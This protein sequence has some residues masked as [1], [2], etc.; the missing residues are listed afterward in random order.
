MEDC[1]SDIHLWRRIA[2]LFG[3]QSLHTT[4]IRIRLCCHHL[5]RQRADRR[6]PL[7]IV[8]TGCKGQS[9]L[10]YGL[11]LTCPD[12]PN[13]LHQLARWLCNRYREGATRRMQIPITIVSHPLTGPCSGVQTRITRFDGAVGWVEY[14]ETH[15]KDRRR[16]VSLTF[17]PSYKTLLII[18]RRSRGEG[19][20]RLARSGQRRQLNVREI[21]LARVRLAPGRRSGA[22]PLRV[23]PRPRLSRPPYQRREAGS[24]NRNSVHG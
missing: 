17:S 13:W 16:W 6:I 7:A 21:L 3:E 22:S 23:I 10:G 4:E 11:Q 12:Q 8:A 20:R 2:S 1:S 5:G 24:S 15:R 19:S 14:R 9:C 18:E